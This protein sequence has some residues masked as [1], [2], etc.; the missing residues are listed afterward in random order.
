MENPAP[1][2]VG[3]LHVHRRDA[4][5]RARASSRGHAHP[6]PSRRRRDLRPVH[7]HQLEMRVGPDGSA[8][9]GRRERPGGLRQ[10]ASGDVRLARHLPRRRVRR[11]GSRLGGV[12]GNVW[13]RSR[14]PQGGERRHEG[15]DRGARSRRFRRGGGEG[16]GERRRSEGVLAA[17]CALRGAGG[18]R[19]RASHRRRAHL[20][21]LRRRL[22]R[23]SHRNHRNRYEGKDESSPVRSGLGPHA[24]D[25]CARRHAGGRRHLRYQSPRI[26]RRPPS[27]DARVQSLRRGQRVPRVFLRIRRGE[28]RGGRA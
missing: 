12:S 5:R 14:G 10:M 18:R 6:R 9:E 15:L 1:A 2:A 7:P 20:H 25:R 23:R 16:D 24:R 3:H 27:P 21:R 4:H 26:R 17:G 8:V 28:P 22:R 11:R 19:R 13:K